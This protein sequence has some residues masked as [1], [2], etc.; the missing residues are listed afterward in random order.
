MRLRLVL[1]QSRTQHGLAPCT[2]WGWDLVAERFLY[3]L[4]PLLYMTFTEQTRQDNFLFDLNSW[5]SL[6]QWSSWWLLLWPVF[7]YCTSSVT[8]SQLK[9]DVW[10]SDLLLTMQNL[11][12][13]VCI[14]SV[15]L[16]AHD[17]KPHES[18][19]RFLGVAKS[20][21][22]STYWLLALSLSVVAE[23]QHA[24]CFIIASLKR[25]LLDSMVRICCS[26]Y[27]LKIKFEH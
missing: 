16:Q 8:E 13:F 25:P 11:K 23:L 18:K 20:R 10:M 15:P 14:I 6:M 22:V 2:Q 3:K 5:G 19:T 27:V 4:L 17:V 21:G 9:T 26:A 12:S 24:W 7:C 1:L